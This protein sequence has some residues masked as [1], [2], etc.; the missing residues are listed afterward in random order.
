MDLLKDQHSVRF[1]TER[2][3]GLHHI[4]YEVADLEEQM[5]R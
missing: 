4:C 5:P 3:G 1:L 2:G